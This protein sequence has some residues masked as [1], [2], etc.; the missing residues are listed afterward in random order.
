MS[1]SSSFFLLLITLI[2]ILIFADGGDPLRVSSLFSFFSFLLIKSIIVF[3]F[4]FSKVTP[5]LCGTLVR[6]GSAVGNEV[7]RFDPWRLSPLKLQAKFQI[8]SRVN[9]PLFEALLVGY[10]PAEA[11]FVS[12][13]L[14]RG[15]PMGLVPNGPTPPT[16][17]WAHSFVSASD[18]VVINTYLAAEIV[19]GRIFGPFTLP[20]RGVF[21]GNSVV[22]PMSLTFKKDGRPRIISN[23]SAGGKL[24]SVNGFIPQAGRTT[25]YPSFREVA[26]AMVSVGLNTVF[27][28]F[29]TLKMHIGLSRFSLRIGNI[30]SSVGR[31]SRGAL[32]C[33]FSTPSW[34]LAEVGTAKSL[35]DSA[36]LSFTF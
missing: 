22:Y 2:L 20:P 28:S 10:N 3:D 19:A 1:F 8:S 4:F 5:A 29:L 30:P 24:L 36:T 32:G 35:T 13:G 21:W 18:R 27:F 17:L 25:S 33:T 26:E 6:S 14:H 7:W 23:L 16:K 15:F 11:L 31:K 9:I 12:N 34:S